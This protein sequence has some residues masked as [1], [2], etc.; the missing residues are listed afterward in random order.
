MEQRIE[1]DPR[2]PGCCRS[3]GEALA[4]AER[5]PPGP[6]RIALAAGEYRE[7]ARVARAGLRIEGAGM[8]RTAIRWGDSAS[9]LLPDGERMGTFN[10]YVL[11]VGAPGVSLEGLT[12]EN[13][14]GD[15]RVVGQAVA[16]YADADRLSVTRCAILG[17]QDSLFAGPLPKDP[18]PKGVNLVHPVAGLGADEP[19]LPFRQHYRGCLVAGDVDFIF[20]SALAVFEGCEIRSLPRDGEETWIAAPST[21]PG[22]EAGFVFHRCALSGPGVAPGS[23]YLGRPWRNRARAAYVDCEMGSHIAPIGWDDW[24]KPEARLT[25]VFAERGSTGPG[26]RPR[27]RAPWARALSAADAEALSPGRLLWEGFPRP[28]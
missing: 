28:T 22:Q 12:I 6:V 4:A 10:S 3:L 20:G 15:G 25:A 13:D 11:Y 24:G 8:G 7:K 17:R 27:D 2:G 1:V 21:Y 14:A 9:A 19:A 23:A 16:L 18:A 5:L 26:A